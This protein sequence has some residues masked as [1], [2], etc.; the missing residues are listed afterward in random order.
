MIKKTAQA[1]LLKSL[2]QKLAS[3]GVQAYVLPKTDEFMSAYIPKEKD[4]L[5]K[6]TNFTG[7][8]GM[9]IVYAD[10]VMYE[11]GKKAQRKPLFITDSRYKL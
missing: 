3:K 10:G 5:Y 6:L 7:S 9:V 11:D 8:N 2:R 1:I 4:K